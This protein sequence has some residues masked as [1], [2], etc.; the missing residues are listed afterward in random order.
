MNRNQVGFALWTL[1][2]TAGAT[3]VILYQHFLHTGAVLGAL[4][5]QG[6]AAQTLPGNT[7]AASPGVQGAQSPASG[8][9][10]PLGKLGSMFAYTPGQ[11]MQ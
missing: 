11:Y 5:A 8:V 6:N 9:W 7:I 2:I 4:G 1:A 3:A 10:T